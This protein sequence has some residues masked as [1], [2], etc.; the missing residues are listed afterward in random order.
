M[1]ERVSRIRPTFQM[2]PSGASL[3]ATVGVARPVAVATVIVPVVA[4]PVV[5]S[6]FARA[7]WRLVR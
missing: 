2:T 1:N 4:V 5:A 7:Y 6:V 3:R